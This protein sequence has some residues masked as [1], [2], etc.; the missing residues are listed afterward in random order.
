M[1]RRPGIH[2]PLRYC[3]RAVLK[4]TLPMPPPSRRFSPARSI[5]RHALLCLRS[6]LAS[7]S[8]KRCSLKRM[9]TSCV[10]REAM[11]VFADYYQFY[12][13]DG[14]LN[15]PAPEDW[16]DADIAHRVKAAPNVVVICPVRNMTVAVEVEL[17]T[18]EPHF[19]ASEVDHVVA[20]SLAVPTGHLQVHE[21]T[22][23]PVLNWQIDPGHY[24]L[25]ALF[26]RLGTVSADGLDGDDRYR[27]LLW[28]GA[29]RSLRVVQEWS[30]P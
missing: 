22:G 29:E 12:V 19:D 20:C 1:S 4:L 2:D 6:C 24:Q 5:R 18:S 30:G 9:T 7:A 16:T 8:D 25:L 26:Y 10:H 21:C 3:P 15:P 13:Q 23:G 27:V 28:P 17:H 14:Q 11:E